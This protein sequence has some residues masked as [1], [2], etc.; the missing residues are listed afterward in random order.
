MLGARAVV[1]GSADPTDLAVKLLEP[2]LRESLGPDAYDRAY[3]TGM[4]RSRDEALAFLDPATL[5]AVQA[6]RM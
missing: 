4:A 6:R 5:L 3:A 1:R 2:R